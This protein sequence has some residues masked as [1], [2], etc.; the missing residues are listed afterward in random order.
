MVRVEL[1]HG[2]EDEC[3]SYVMHVRMVQFAELT[4]RG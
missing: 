2:G 1:N 3:G 4:T